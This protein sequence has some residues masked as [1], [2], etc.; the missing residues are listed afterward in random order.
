MRFGGASRDDANDFLVVFL[1]ERMNYEQNRTRPYGSDR[2]PAFLIHKRGVTL[3]YGIGVIEHQDGSFKPNIMLAKILTVLVLI[4]FKS[5]RR[6]LQEQ[7]TRC[8]LKVS[9]HMYVHFF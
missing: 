7:N 8:R 2:Y 9:I 1:M 5:H 4:P 3:R 6:Q